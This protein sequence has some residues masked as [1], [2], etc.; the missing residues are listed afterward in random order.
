MQSELSVTGPKQQKLTQIGYLVAACSITA[1]Q[2]HYVFIKSIWFL[3]T[4]KATSLTVV[5]QSLKLYSKY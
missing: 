3:E 2:E 5:T 4:Y 1:I